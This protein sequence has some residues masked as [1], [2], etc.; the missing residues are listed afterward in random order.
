MSK[1]IQKSQRRRSAYPAN[2]VHLASAR[3]PTPMRILVLDRNMR[4]LEQIGRTLWVWPHLLTAAKSVEEARELSRSFSP[5]IVIA[6]IDFLNKSSNSGDISLRD[7]FPNIPV[8]ALGASSD[9]AELGALL[10]TGADALLTYE[11]LSRSNLHSTLTHIQQVPQAINGEI[12]SAVTLLPIPWQNSRI[13]GTLICEV[14]GTIVAAND[15]LATWLEY[16]GAQALV[17]K[18]VQGDILH[19]PEDWNTWPDTAGC[20][21]SYLQQTITVKSNNQQHLRARVEVFAAPDLPTR[22][23]AM[24]VY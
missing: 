12:A 20:L 7:V 6:C 4:A 15:Y 3:G 10:G 16:S 11:N 5:T 23:Q 8:V 2:A 18:S 19:N 22:L 17:G 13:V 9:Y 24:F 21:T 14:D 1:I